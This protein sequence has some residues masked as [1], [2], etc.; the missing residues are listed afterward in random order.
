MKTTKAPPPIADLVDIERRLAIGEE[1]VSLNWAKRTIRGL[2]AEVLRLRAVL[3]DI[4]KQAKWESQDP[5]DSGRTD[6]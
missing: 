4:S 6:D 3:A 5:L 1:A 2:V